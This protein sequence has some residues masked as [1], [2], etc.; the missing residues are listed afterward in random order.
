MEKK[1]PIFLTVANQLNDRIA[2][3]VYVSSQKL[4]SEYELAKEFNVSRLTVR[5]AIDHLIKQNI[6]VKRKG[7]GTYIM[8]TPKIQSGKDGLL[9]FSETAKIYKKTAHT[10]LL[11]FED[12]IYEKDLWE[13]LNAK[14]EEKIYRI[15]RLRKYD[16]EPMTL[17]N[18][19]IRA[20]FLGEVDF[21]EL[22]GSLFKLIEK[23]SDIA[24]SHQEIQATNLTEDLAQKLKV[25]DGTAA[26]VVSSVTY[27]ANGTPLFYDVSYYHGD[28]YTFKVTLQ[29]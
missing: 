7:Y 10:K 8:Q 21:N 13:K 11:Q 14:P 16:T 24:Y 15:V 19:C 12:L 2:K 17:E 4:P 28:K 25:P 5:K 20:C 18:I 3:K 23:H 26:L 9:S 22:T 27:A 1:Q 6:L 29:R